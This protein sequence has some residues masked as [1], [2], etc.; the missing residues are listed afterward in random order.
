MNK[1]VNLRFYKNT[2]FK[3]LHELLSD[4]ITKKYFPF[5]YTIVEEQSMLRLKTRIEDQKWGID[6]RF[7][8]EDQKIK[9]AVGEISGRS[10]K[11]DNSCMDLAILIHPKFRGKGY[12]KEGTLKFIEKM[13]KLK[14]NIVRF[15]MV[16]AESNKASQ[17]VAKKLNFELKSTEEFEI[18]KNKKFQFWE[19]A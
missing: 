6:T 14:P 10:L 13:R 12:A 7:V 8:I 1:N 19:K 15:R 2:D 5:M 9:K 16:I 11:E 4:E 18:G 17:A 3:F